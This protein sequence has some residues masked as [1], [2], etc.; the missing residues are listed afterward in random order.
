MDKD[1]KAIIILL[2]TQAMINMGEIQ[3]PI[4]H[5]AKDDLDGA[6]VFIELLDIL[7]S[8]TQGNLTTEEEAFL[9]EV[10][11]NLDQ[12]YNKKISAG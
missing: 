7:E 6:A 1:I 4:T 9:I 8:K 5:E 12:V 3:D 11:E 2:A 10:R